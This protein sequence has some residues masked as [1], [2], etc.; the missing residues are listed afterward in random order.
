MRK[1][2]DFI[3]EIVF[4]VPLVNV[5][6]RQRLA[7]GEW[8]GKAALTYR[9]DPNVMLFADI[10]R[11]VKS[12]VYDL[13]HGLR[14]RYHRSIRKS[15]CPMKPALSPTVLNRRLQ[16]NATGF[17]YDYRDQQLQGVFSVRPSAS[18]ALSTC[19]DPTFMAE[20]RDHCSTCRCCRDRQSIGYKT[21]Q[22]DEFIF[23]NS[24]ATIALRDPRPRFLQ[25]HRHQRSVG[26]AAA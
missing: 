11:G 13:Q 24:P 23:V 7:R 21:G 10:A 19:H 9:I 8:S 1:L 25:H 5:R 6:T 26:R 17:Y 2:D 4:P 20:S 3:S 18:A 14:A 16:V 15:C 12:G 22:Y